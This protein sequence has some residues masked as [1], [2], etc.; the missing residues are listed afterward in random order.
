MKNH[1]NFQNS[2][3]F[4]IASAVVIIAS[5]QF[6]SIQ[7]EQREKL[8]TLA[9][10]NTPLSEYKSLNQ[11]MYNTVVAYTLIQSIAITTGLV[12]FANILTKKELTS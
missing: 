10:L 7:T 6:R 3:L 2:L 9:E 1:K 12:A 11:E 8:T 5:I 4:L